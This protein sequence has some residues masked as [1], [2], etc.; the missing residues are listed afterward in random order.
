MSLFGLIKRPKS[1]TIAAPAGAVAAPVMRELPPAAV[2]AAVPRPP[3]EPT[4]DEVRQLLF[5]ALASGDERRLEEIRRD[6]R[7]AIERHID[8][9]MIVPDALCDNAEV[10]EWYT[11]GVR[12]LAAQPAAAG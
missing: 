2:G 9:W 8:E 6:H 5:D 10:A 1:A 11:R 4:S 12:L 7:E 3:A